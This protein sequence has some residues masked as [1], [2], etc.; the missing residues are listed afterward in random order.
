MNDRRNDRLLGHEQSSTEG[1]K[2]KLIAEEANTA[3]G[4]LQEM[5][6]EVGARTKIRKARAEFGHFI[7]FSNLTDYQRTFIIATSIIY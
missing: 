5:L 1:R 4:L 3:T 2:D 7:P 6:S